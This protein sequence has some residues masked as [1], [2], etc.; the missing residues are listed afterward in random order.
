M[1]CIYSKSELVGYGR[2]N[3]IVI[4]QQ[5]EL[6]SKSLLWCQTILRSLDDLSLA[7][8]EDATVA[9]G[10]AEYVH[11]PRGTRSTISMAYSAD[12]SFVAS[13]HGDHTV[14]V[15]DSATNRVMLTLYGHPRTP[16]TVKFHPACPY[17]IASGCL[18]FQ[19]RLWD[20]RRQS[21]PRAARLPVADPRCLQ[22]IE[23]DKEIISISFHPTYDILAIASGRGLFIWPFNA[24]GCPMCVLE[25]SHTLRC[26]N[27]TPCGRYLVTGETNPALAHMPHDR[28]RPDLTVKLILWR[29]DHAALRDAMLIVRA[30]PRRLPSPFQE[31]GL[32]IHHAVLYNDGGLDLSPCGQYVATCQYIEVSDGIVSHGGQNITYGG[33]ARKTARA[34]NVV[35][36][37]TGKKSSPRML[38]GSFDKILDLRLV[39]SLRAVGALLPA[40]PRAVRHHATSLMSRL[41]RND[42]ASD[43]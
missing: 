18:G 38:S 24:P 6:G 10:T 3:I 25:R 12:G 30:E 20:L 41:G 36:N 15:T 1:T 35:R 27:F 16:W 2:S 39:R 32:V 5:R 43:C 40:F 21:H 31:I 9:Q 28:T 33:C 11:L 29:V 7:W 4:L 14:K 19:V 42:E 8:A 17:L 13:T 37:T 22:K 34:E 26:V 23:L